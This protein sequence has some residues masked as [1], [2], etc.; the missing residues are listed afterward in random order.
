MLR[1]ELGLGRPIRT[2]SVD[3]S[4]ALINN[5]GFLEAERIRLQTHGWTYNPPMTMWHLPAGTMSERFPDM[6]KRAFFLLGR[7]GRSSHAHSA[8]R[9]AAADAGAVAGYALTNGLVY[10]L[11]HNT[12]RYRRPAT[13][14]QE[15]LGGL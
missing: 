15:R 2:A 11:T 6:A 3:S 13:E 9:R 7:C 10:T 5:S 4:K 1:Q 14:H 12:R 8:L